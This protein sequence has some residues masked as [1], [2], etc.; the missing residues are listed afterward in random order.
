VEK[1]EVRKTLSGCSIQPRASIHPGLKEKNT[2]RRFA[3]QNARKRLSGRL[4]FRLG[5]GCKESGGAYP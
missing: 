3:L 4:R 1:A 2:R 5:F